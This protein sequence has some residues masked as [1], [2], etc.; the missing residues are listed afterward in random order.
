MLPCTM[1]YSE[2]LEGVCKS[3]GETPFMAFPMKKRIDPELF[4]DLMVTLFNLRTQIRNVTSKNNQ[5][6]WDRL[7]GT[8]A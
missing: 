3:N 7:V 6:K 8:I 5:R 2:V 1:L 4:I